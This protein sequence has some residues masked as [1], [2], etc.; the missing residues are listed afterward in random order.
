MRRFV[1]HPTDIPIIVQEA[2]EQHLESA[3]GALTS[4]SQGGLSCLVDT[5]FDVGCLVDIDIPSVSPAYH[6]TGEVV[7]CEFRSGRFEVGLRFIDTE[8]AFK[9][10]MIQQICQIEHYKK[11]V[12]EN[13]GRVLDGNQAAQEWIEKYASLF[14]EMT[15]H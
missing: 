2:R 14:D 15:S 10:R 5:H 11:T 9:S 8:E 13:E 7:W 12:F 3:D 4:V 6:G 1:R